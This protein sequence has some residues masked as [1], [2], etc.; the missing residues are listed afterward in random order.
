MKDF[1]DHDDVDYYKYVICKL[2]M[3][4][5]I[6]KLIIVLNLVKLFY[7]ESLPLY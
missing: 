4:L 7:K 1:N 3:I 6:V 5:L 2:I